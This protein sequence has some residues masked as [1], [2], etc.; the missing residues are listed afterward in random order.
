[1]FVE[2]RTC[3]DVHS[4]GGFVKMCMFIK[5]GVAVEV[6]HKCMRKWKFHKDVYENGGF[7]KMFTLMEV[8]LKCGTKVVVFDDSLAH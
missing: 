3:K 1:M 4:N 5:M 2:W 8:L 7:T 6:S